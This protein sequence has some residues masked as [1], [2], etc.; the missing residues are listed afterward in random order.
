MIHYKRYRKSITCCGNMPFEVSLQSILKIISTTNINGLVLTSKQIN[1]I[2]VNE[3][4][5]SSVCL[6]INFPLVIELPGMLRR[7]R[8]K[9]AGDSIDIVFVMTDELAF[10]SSSDR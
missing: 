6:R 5:T 8:P 10:A 9:L 2:R 4:R 7:I 1:I 3:E